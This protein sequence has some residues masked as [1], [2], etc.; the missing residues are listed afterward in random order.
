MRLNLVQQLEKLRMQRRLSARG[1]QD[2]D[3]ALA[4]DQPLNPRLQ[5]AQRRRLD[6]LLRAPERRIREADRA[7]QIARIDNFNQSQTGG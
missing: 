1:L 4:I 6:L 5:P 2:F 3:P 7:A